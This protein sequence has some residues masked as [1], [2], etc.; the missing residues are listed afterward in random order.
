MKQCSYCAGRG[1]L[2]E[3]C[4]QRIG[5]YRSTNYTSQIVSHQKIYKDRS[6]PLGDL[7]D[8]GSFYAL[9]TP[10]HFKWSSPKMPKNSYYSRFLV[11]VN[12]ARPQAIKRKSTSALMEV[13]AKVYYTHDYIPNA[14]AKA[15]RG[16]VPPTGVESPAKPKE[17][18][19]VVEE[20]TPAEATVTN[21]AVQDEPVPDE[22]VQNEPLPD[23][24]VEEEQPAK[25]DATVSV[26]REEVSSNSL[27]QDV[28][29]TIAK[30]PVTSHELD[31]D[32]NYSFSEHFEV[33]SSTTTETSSALPANHPLANLPDIIPLSGSLDDDFAVSSHSQGISMCVNANASNSSSSHNRRRS[34][35]SYMEAPEEETRDIPCEG[36]IIM[37]RDQSEYLFSPEGRTFLAATAK[38]CQVSVRMDFKDY[39]YVLVIYGLKEHQEDLQLKLLRRH[40]EVKRKTIEFQS[41]KPPKRIDVL[42][43]F[44]RDGI[45][46]LTSNLGNAK[47]HYLR[48]KAL[49]EMNTKN[50]FKMAEKKRR[51][52]NMILVGQAGLLNGNTHLD[53]LVVLLRRLLDDFS[54]DENAT[55]ELRN[56]IEEHWRMIFTAYPHPNYDSLI[57]SYGRLDQKNRLPS[58]HLDPILLGLQEKKAPPSPAK[59]APSPTPPPPTWQHMAPPPPPPKMPKKKQR[60]A[61]L[62]QQQTQQQ[63]QLQEMM[64]Q[65]Q[66]QQQQLDSIIQ[67][68]QSNQQQQQH[69]LQQQHQQQQK[70]QQQQQP[71][72][73]QQRQQQNHQQQ[74]QHMVQQQ[75]HHQ[76]QQQ[77]RLQQQQQHR[78]QQQQQQR[79]QQQQQNNQ[80]Q[81]QMR[82]SQ[83]THIMPFNNPQQR[84]RADLQLRQTLNPECVNLL[85]EMERSERGG[86]I[87]KD[88]NKPSMFWSRESLKY[89]DDLFKMTS[90]TDTVERL[91]R[92]LQRSQRGQLSHNDYRAVIRLHSLLQN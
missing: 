19:V 31:S 83:S 2:F 91:H 58:M 43:R 34:G 69:R 82:R 89:L 85:A 62:Q 66:D 54:P 26:Q 47:S 60:Q 20:S 16:E 78:Q 65:H 1:H 90:N 57:N 55:P 52:L 48:I 74:L 11:H 38:Q 28:E 3:N 77:Q 23:E 9:E 49:E 88:A 80:Q 84:A 79:L 25:E 72:Q 10:F 46:S 18:P 42:I 14:Q 36:K 59:R 21:V 61:L 24:P 86:S 33:P 32:S 37:A 76:Q 35:D 15:A 13:P 92:V 67:Q 30:Q 87:N 70:Q 53:Q 64:K 4:R 63:Q 6:G 17:K 68:Q 71:K 12:L 39:G 56:E 22:P 40:Q 27:T 73:Q 45:N 29:A 7:G 51:Q 75:Q 41:Q 5:D 44:L 50:G 8:L 81:Q